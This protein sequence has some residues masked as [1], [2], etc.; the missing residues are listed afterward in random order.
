MQVTVRPGTLGTQN[1]VITAPPSK[2]IAH[3][4]VLCAGLAKGLSLVKNLEFSQDIKATLAGVGQGCAKVKCGENS[5]RIEGHGGFATLVKPVFCDESGSTLRFFIPVFSLTGQKVRFTG[6]GRLFER[7]MGVYQKIFESQRLQ[8]TQTSQDIT[9][10]GALG[11]GEYE[12]PGNVSSQFISGLLFALPLLDKPSKIKILPPFESRSYVQLTLGVLHDFGVQ[13]DWSSE[14][15]DTLLIPGGQSYH[16]RDYTVEGDYSQAAFFAVLGALKGGITINGLRPDTRQGDAAILDILQRCGAKFER[17][18]DSVRFE[19]S[20]LHAAEIDLADC[21]DLGPVLMVLGC[22]CAGRTHIANAARLR[23]KESDRIAAMQ[24]ELAKFGAKI[25]STENDVYI[26]GGVPLSLP[27]RL[28]G[29]NDHRVV[30]S[31][32]V[33]ALGAGFTAVVDDAQAVRK[34]WPDFFEVLAKTGAEVESETD[35]TK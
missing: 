33:C 18:G 15:P 28:H 30:M 7:P 23:L 9:I 12:L 1:A 32:A 31:L 25:T 14:E 27:G 8:F 22:F 6:A 13:A 21:P 3:R 20:Q 17:Y 26:E 16:N 35:G 34:S 24:A 2:S 5:A 4:A 29:H 19:K 10:K 11:G